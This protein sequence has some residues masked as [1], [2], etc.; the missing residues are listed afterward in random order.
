MR[1]EPLS[2][3]SK[4]V[5]PSR[6]LFLM[7]GCAAVTLVGCQRQQTG[8]AGHV[9][10]GL[11]V[12]AFNPSFFNLIDPQKH[13]IR[14]ADGF[15]WAEG[16]CWDRR[17]Q[18]LYFSDIPN[19]KIHIWS[20]S[21][22]LGTFLHPAG[23]PDGVIDSFAS[24]GTNGILYLHEEQQ[25]LICNQDGR[26]IDSYDLK[27]DQRSVIASHYRE[28]K[29]NSPND[30]ARTESGIIFFT[31]PSYGLADLDASAG[32]EQAH[33]GVY[34]LSQDGAVSLVSSDMTFPNGVGLS[35]DE[36]TLYVSQSDASAPHI[37]AFDVNSEGETSNPRV[38][39]NLS[40]YMAPDAHGLPDGM[41]IDIAGNVFATG[42]GGVFVISPNGTILGRIRTDRATANCAF[43]GDGRTLF[44]TAHQ[45]LLSIETKT[46]G[47][48]FA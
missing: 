34:R 13:P 39:A 15:A 47:H 7:S 19:N 18:R 23:R 1:S 43:G 41:A 27:S 40:S 30:L 45:H 3:I 21:G 12:E 37:M 10:R 24:P 20:L 38:W 5:E 48:G 25:L 14:L 11:D 28:K 36:S 6:R 31:D 44:M 16:P 2:S 42:P 17:R 29:F 35:P 9:S 26:S 22:G 46:T 4:R 8:N 33:N 32:K